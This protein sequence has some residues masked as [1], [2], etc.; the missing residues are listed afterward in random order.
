MTARAVGVVAVMSA[1]ILVAVAPG[2]PT[3]MT[4]MA[5]AGPKP[6][7]TVSGAAD[8]NT[9]WAW[10]QKMGEPYKS[11]DGALQAFAAALSASDIAGIHAACPRIRG[12]GRMFEALLPSPVA[13]ATYRIQAIADDLYQAADGC[14][15]LGP[16]ANWTTA[17]DML[18]HVKD[19]QDNLGTV[20]SIL[21]PNG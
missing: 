10:F 14:D 16:G 8:P 4:P 11:M 21:A 3:A 12:A 9:K 20:K 7:A 5:T 6:T 17:G 18:S 13:R 19:A 2:T 15:A 1:V